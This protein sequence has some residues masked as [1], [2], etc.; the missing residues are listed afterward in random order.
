MNAD[1][2]LNGSE[3]ALSV[4]W[5]NWVDVIGY[6]KSPFLF[7]LLLL[8]V[9]IKSMHLFDGDNPISQRVESYNGEESALNNS[10]SPD[11]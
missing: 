8:L 10:E 1:S 4:I 5:C 3:S 6:I 7:V 9:F 11:L 2:D